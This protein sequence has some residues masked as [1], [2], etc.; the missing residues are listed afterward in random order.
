MLNIYCDYYC[1]SILN[2]LHVIC[3]IH[4]NIKVLNNQEMKQHKTNYIFK[5]IIVTIFSTFNS[6]TTKSRQIAKTSITTDTII[7]SI[8]T[9]QDCFIF[10]TIQPITI[11]RQLKI[12]F[13]S[14]RPQ[15]LIDEY[16][17]QLFIMQREIGLQL[18]KKSLGD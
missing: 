10:Y 1:K 7:S 15:F 12:N 8:N 6:R 3:E 11:I 9:I 17:G 18:P 4:L 2:Y 16:A 14:L 5:I 13:E